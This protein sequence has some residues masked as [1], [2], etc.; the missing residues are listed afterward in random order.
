MTI[1]LFSIFI[2]LALV[3]IGFAIWPLLRRP[4]MRGR[5]LLIGAIAALI[6][7]LGLGSYVLL[8]SPALALRTLAGPSNDD[9]RGM[10]S[11]LA[12]R[13]LDRPNDARGWTLL[14]RG[15]LTLNDPGD[16]A[17]AF[18][19]G[20][21]VTPPAQRHGLLSAYAE[22]LT[23]A[24]NGAVGPEA[25]AAFTDAL[26][27]N[28]RDRAARFYL[29]Q[30]A[31][32]RGDNARA[33]TLWSSLLP[34]IPAN[35]PLHDVLLNRI[36]MLRAQTGTA[37]D[38]NA[39][40]EGLAARLKSNPDDA[41]GWR[42]LVRAYSVL[43]QKDKARDALADGREALKKDAAGLAALNAEAATDNL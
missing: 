14:G 23:L 1:L 2:L 42:R 7:G 22:A 38:I 9:I 21:A 20:L 3:A 12:R 41:S 11:V 19:R 32:Q 33:L 24:A 31:A 18:K 26:K 36:A 40:V 25:E 43:G 17:A 13:V 16:A 8:G 4:A 6:L 39:M 28:P 29:G 10:V 34:E 35:N 27:S 15:Y 5:L 30:V 37:P